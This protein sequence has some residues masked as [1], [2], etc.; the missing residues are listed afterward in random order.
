MA[1]EVANKIKASK[2][3][4]KASKRHESLLPDTLAGGASGLVG[5]VENK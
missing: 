4:K 3:N 5:T 1:T 2:S